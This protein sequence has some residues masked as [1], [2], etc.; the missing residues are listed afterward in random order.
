MGQRTAFESWL[1]LDRRG[2][3]CIS[4]IALDPPGRKLYLGLEDGYVEEHGIRERNG[5]CTSLLAARKQVAKKASSTAAAAAADVALPAAW[6]GRRLS[7]PLAPCRCLRRPLS[8]CRACG[9]RAAWPRYA[10]T[11]A[12]RSSTQSR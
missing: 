8:A 4:A 10:P 1:V 9:Q 7:R 12:C 11:A 2:S 5:A 6:E 3:A